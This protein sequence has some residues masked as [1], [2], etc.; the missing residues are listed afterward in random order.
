MD[1][2]VDFTGEKCSVRYHSIYANS[3]IIANRFK[4]LVISIKY[5]T[6]KLHLTAYFVFLLNFVRI[7]NSNAY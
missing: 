2:S 5:L 1:I 7:S 3:D 4:V 6:A